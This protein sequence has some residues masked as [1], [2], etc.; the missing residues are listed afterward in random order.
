MPKLLT[1][2][3][4]EDCPHKKKIESCNADGCT[5]M[6]PPLVVLYG[7][8]DWC[9]LND[10]PEPAI[11]ADLPPGASFGL[12]YAAINFLLRQAREDGS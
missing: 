3:S 7:I 1:I 8:P 10:A 12:A 5:A 4:C 2:N 11:P 6:S 9:P